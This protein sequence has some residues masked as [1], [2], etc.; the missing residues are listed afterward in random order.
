MV[1]RPVEQLQQVPQVYGR[2]AHRDALGMGSAPTEQLGNYP[3][4]YS[5]RATVTPR[6]QS[7]AKS[8]VKASMTSAIRRARR[9][10]KLHKH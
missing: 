9:V 3:R 10:F 7:L 4:S 6:T 5:S 1:E 8:D 2:A